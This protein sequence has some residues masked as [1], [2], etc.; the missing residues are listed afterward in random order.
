MAGAH[1]GPVAC[2]AESDGDDAA[3]QDLIQKLIAIDCKL[4]QVWRRRSSAAAAASVPVSARP[5]FVA[6]W[7]RK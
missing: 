1:D 4:E 5:R 7:S 6:E 3:G 2:C